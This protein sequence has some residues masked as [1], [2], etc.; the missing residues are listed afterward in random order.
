MIGGYVT[1]GAFAAGLAAAA[2]PAWWLHSVRVDQLQ[3]TIDRLTSAAEVARQE[4]DRRAAAAQQQID[5]VT[6][7]LDVARNTRE[8]VH[9]EVVREIQA[10]ASADRQCL[11]PAAVSVLQRSQD[12]RDASRQG[13]GVSAGTGLR[14]ATDPVRPASE[15]AVAE[16]MAAALD[17][18]T[19]LRDRHRALADIV[20]V[21]PCVEIV[22]DQ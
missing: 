14:I 10:A 21:L 4:S 13:P 1:A 5:Q 20:R 8:V 11:G 6:A 17:Q 22:P 18:Y 16:W 9:V 2:V 15:R 3:L 7:A 19:G 12:R